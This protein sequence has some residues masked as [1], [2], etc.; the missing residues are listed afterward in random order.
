MLFDGHLSLVHSVA[1]S[2]GSSCSSTVFSCRLTV[3]LCNALPFCQ[4]K[5]PFSRRKQI[6]YIRIQL[7]CIVTSLLH[8]SILQS[9]TSSKSSIIRFFN[10]KL[11]RPTF[12]LRGYSFN[13]MT[14]KNSLLL[15]DWINRDDSSS[16]HCT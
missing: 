3:L 14:R 6:I 15:V 7:L 2:F 4:E 13:M 11:T 5:V 9:N 1:P 12:K 16:I 8:L 10:P